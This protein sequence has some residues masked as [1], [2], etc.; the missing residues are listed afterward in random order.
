MEM[1]KRYV[2]NIILIV[3]SLSKGWYYSKETKQMCYSENRDGPEMPDDARTML[4]LTEIAN[5][6]DRDIVMT[7]DY[8]SL[9]EDKRLPVLDLNL[10]I[11]GN[12]VHFGFF[13]KECASPFTILYRSALS[14]N[15][16]RNSIF[17]EGLRRLRNMSSGINQ[18]EKKFCCD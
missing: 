7:A 1:Y 8:C 17:Q 9:H 4:C 3:R 15:T 13:K 5:E 16:K 6:L 14:A 11:Q 18:E 10:F 12:R 2:D